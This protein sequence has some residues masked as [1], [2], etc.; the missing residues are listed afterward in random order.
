MRALM[1]PGFLV[2]A[3]LSA[4]CPGVGYTVT[5][6]GGAY[7]PDLVYAAPGVQ[8]IADFDEPIFYADNF[9]WRQQGTVW[10]RSTDYRSGW[11]Y[12]P[13]PPSIR[14]IDR[15][16]RYAHYRPQGWTPRHGQ[17]ARDHREPYPKAMRQPPPGPMPPPGGSPHGGPPQGGPPPRYDQ[18]GDRDHRNDRDQRD[19]GGPR[20]DR[21]QRNDRDQ[22]DHRD[23]R[24]HR[25]GH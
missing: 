6:S 22:R 24:D 2:A 14:G 15:P 8:V 10:Y 17:P 19:R 3:A 12:A 13:P 7:G 4:G 16:D 23:S 11:V 25:D 21:G 5:A 9:Y 1:L 18:G 20:D